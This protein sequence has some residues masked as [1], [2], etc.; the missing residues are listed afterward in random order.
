MIFRLSSNLAAKLKV[1]PSKVLL[2]DENP[3]ADWSAHLFI[4]ERTQFLIVTN[5]ASLYSTVLYCR[6][7]AK[8]SHFIERALSSLREFWRTTACRS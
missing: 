2:L 8:K 1:T 4:A 6:G 7:I 3:L 5:T